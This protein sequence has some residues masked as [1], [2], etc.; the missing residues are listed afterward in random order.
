MDR[1]R[2]ENIVRQRAA[3]GQDVTAEAALELLARIAWLK[4]E[5]ERLR[6]ENTRLREA[7]KAITPEERAFAAIDRDLAPMWRKHE[8]SG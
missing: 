8:T 4:A 1:E 6:D 5:N 3:A 2:L 7:S